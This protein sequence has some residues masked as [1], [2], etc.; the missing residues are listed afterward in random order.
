MDPP[1]LWDQMQLNRPTREQMNKTTNLSLLE[2]LEMNDINEP[3]LL[4]R[5]DMNNP[6]GMS[7]QGMFSL[8]LIMKTPV[9]MTWMAM[10]NVTQ[11]L[12][13]SNTWMIS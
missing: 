5:L 8:D 1:A 3:L 9:K 10:N 2:R 4:Q 13:V 11:R 12:S 7:H 6:L